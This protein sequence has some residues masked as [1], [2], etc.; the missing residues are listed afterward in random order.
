ME[1]ETISEAPR[2]LTPS[3]K[4]TRN[5]RGYGW[6]IRILSLDIDRLEKLNN[7]MLEKFGGE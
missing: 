1:K 2:E 7:T 4:L 3:I 6:E 5:S